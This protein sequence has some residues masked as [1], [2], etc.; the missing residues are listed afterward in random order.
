MEATEL[1]NFTGIPIQ[2]LED[3]DIW[4]LVGIV[5]Q[6]CTPIAVLV[7]AWLFER[8]RQAEADDLTAL[9]AVTALIPHI[10][11]KDLYSRTFGLVALRHLARAQS[12]GKV[13]RLIE[14]LLSTSG[15]E[16]PVIPPLHGKDALAGWAFEK[17]VTV[18][19]AE[20]H[21][22]VTCGI[23]I[24]PW[25]IFPGK[26]I[27]ERL[28]LFRD[29]RINFFTEKEQHLV[30]QFNLVVVQS[31]DQAPLPEIDSGPPP[32]KLVVVQHTRRNG[33]CENKLVYLDLSVDQTR[34]GSVK[35]E[36]PKDELCEVGGLATV[37]GRSACWGI[38]WRI[39]G[40][41]SVDLIP[42]EDLINLARK[43]VV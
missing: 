11:S 5:G 39:A 29:N 7:L 20:G 17:L 43:L 30:P 25:L 14:A 23:A 3:K 22:K 33:Q 35:Y 12:G 19:G 28:V 24:G 8:R 10:L 40:N 42:L 6:I 9:Q 15:F 4:D 1:A 38:V 34:A 37:V 21:S 2:V 26:E 27:A 13:L 31:T 32:E 36:L 41:N 18:M 16:L